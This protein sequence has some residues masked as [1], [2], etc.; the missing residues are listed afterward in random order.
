[1]NLTVDELREMLANTGTR[2]DAK[3]I[4]PDQPLDDQ[5]V[6]SLDMATLFLE[7]EERFDITIPDDAK[8]HTLNKIL[9]FINKHI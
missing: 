8:L 2:A 1:M 7:M 5:D 9:D 6:D 4:L 3:T